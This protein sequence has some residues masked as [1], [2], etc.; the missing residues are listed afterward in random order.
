MTNGIQFELRKRNKK[1]DELWSVQYDIHTGEILAIE[2]GSKVANDRLTISFARIK[3]ILEGK[4]SQANFRVGFNEVIGAL[5]LINL[6]APRPAVNNRK[7]QRDR[8]SWLTAGEYQGDPDA[9]LRALLF[10]DHGVLRIE[11]SRMWASGAKEVLSHESIA[12]TIPFFITDMEDPHQLFGHSEIKLTEIIDRGFWETRLWSFIDHEIVTRILYRGQR[13]RI[14]LPSVAHE[15][16]FTR[17]GQYSEFTGIIDDQ[18]IMSHIGPGKHVS[19]FVR[20]GTLWAQSHY[21]PGCAIDQL[22]GHLQI[23]VVNGDNLESFVSWAWLPALLLRQ[24]QPFEVLPDWSYHQ[25]PSALYKA[26]NID[27]GVLS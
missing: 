16:F 5:D 18:T 23:A 17:L 3:E 21:Q 10:N 4:K 2:S 24:S 9:D 26:N 6:R 20:D 8:S 12:E 15:M 19:L 27:I 22:K 1:R 25:L 13:I 7:K 11:A 14:N